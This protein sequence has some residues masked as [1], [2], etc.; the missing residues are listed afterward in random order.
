MAKSGLRDPTRARASRTR[1][2]M[3]QWVILWDEFINE[4]REL[5]GLTTLQRQKRHAAELL[6]EA[7]APLAEEKKALEERKKETT[8]RRKRAH[9]R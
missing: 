6:E 5:D 7:M 9:K 1:P 3:G 8:T 4:I 2:R